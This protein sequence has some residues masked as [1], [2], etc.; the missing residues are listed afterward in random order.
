MNDSDVIAGLNAVF[1][2][3]A[4]APDEIEGLWVDRER[5]DGRMNAILSR[6]R[7]THVRVQHVPRASLD[8]LCPGT[9]H[10]GVVA[11]RR[12]RARPP[13]GDLMGLVE[14]RAQPLLLVLDQ[15]QDPH[16]LGACLR[17]A[18]AAGAHAVIVPRH[19]RAPLSAAA[20]KAACGAAERI[21][22]YEVANLARTLKALKERG[23]WLVGASA[24]GA[25]SL[26]AQAIPESVAFVL[27]GE[28]AGL[29]RLTREACDLLVRIPMSGAAESLNVSVAAALC[30]Y[31][32]VRQRALANCVGA[33]EP[34]E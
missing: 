20:C 33:R 28:G 23:V 15:V 13:E 22:L 19:A 21:P 7:T 5:R 32:S 11:R 2:A 34:L 26:H 30:L 4:A 16:N 12:P 6:A 25:A 29:R 1:A 9:A 18:E 27:G 31:E 8:R 14:T 24:Q 10:Q 17:T 3:L